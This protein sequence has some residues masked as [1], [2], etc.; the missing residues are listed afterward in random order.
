VSVVPDSLTLNDIP[1]S[2]LEEL[3]NLQF[4]L[5]APNVGWLATAERLY[6]TESNGAKWQDLTPTSLT[7]PIVRVEFVD[8]KLGWLVGLD[9]STTP[10]A[11]VVYQTSDGGSIW[12]DKSSNLQKFVN[13]IDFPL[14]STVYAQFEPDGQGWLLIKYATGVNFSLGTLLYTSD[15]GSTWEHREAQSG[16][17][18]YF[19]DG[20]QGYQLAAH[21]SGL[22]STQDGGMTWQTVNVSIAGLKPDTQIQPGLPSVTQDGG[23]VLSVHA[24]REE[25]LVRTYLLE[26]FDQGKSWIETKTALTPTQE[27]LR[28]EPVLETISGSGELTQWQPVVFTP[29]EGS[30][31]KT[32]SDPIALDRLAL[33]RLVSTD[34]QNAWGLFSGGGCL[35][36]ENSPK[37][38]CLQGQV[39]AVT[40]DGGLTWSLMQLPEEVAVLV[41]TQPATPEFG[42]ALQPDATTD[43]TTNWQLIKAQG[44]DTCATV[45]MTRMSTWRASSPYTVYGLY[46]GGAMAYCPN[47]V[48]DATS[49]RVLFNAG[50]RFIPT[51]VGPQ[52]PCTDFRVKFSLDPT[53]AYNEG[54]ANANQAVEALKTRG[55]TNPDGS[56]SVIYYD[57]ERFPYSAACSEAARSF[58]KG[59]TTRLHQTGNKSGLYATSVNINTNKVYTIAPVPDVVWIAEWY[60]TP[61][62]RDW[63]TVFNVDYLSSGYWANNQRIYQY[64]GGHAETWGGLTMSIDNDV[65][66]GM[67]AVP[68]SSDITLPVSKAAL[69]GIYGT[70]PWY[71]SAV[72]VTLT[73]TDNVSG[74]NS[75]YYNLNGTGWK[76]YTAPISVTTD[77]NHT[78]QFRAVDGVYN[79]ESPQSLTFK[80]D[81][82]APGFP[83]GLKSRCPYPG[84][85]QAFCNDESFSWVTATDNLSGLY[86]TSIYWGT[87]PNGTSTTLTTTT[88]DP[89]PIADR[90]TYYLRFR[91]V[92]NAGNSSGWRTLNTLSYD[93]RFNKLQ[94]LPLVTR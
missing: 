24:Y 67:V 20:K 15:A 64:A 45:N 74:I 86:Q 48:F 71:K 4:E 18:F 8:A 59:W 58:L 3:P 6:W 38:T 43:A 9:P 34:G 53:T 77:L 17:P 55:M 93:T 42:K 35:T 84:L 2:T 29:A 87:D 62:Y 32:T 75:I 92:D 41:E 66:D 82:T 37:P 23:L 76:K 56:G 81:S 36:G 5:I 57:L 79:W 13:E 73:A 1:Q 68:Y 54:V 10:V 25:E 51:W 52:A 65:I 63:V 40:S 83:T 33:T 72:S 22:L 39:L 11:I 94:F 21:A 28:G 47:T 19:I 85:K 30:Q 16:E 60:A 90:S 49:L 91:T 50:W 88:F 89:A 78:L 12:Q 70:I 31:P 14:S 69:S 7:L 27:V 26:S 44:F 80:L 46:L 61:Y